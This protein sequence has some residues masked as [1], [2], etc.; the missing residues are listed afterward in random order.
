ML[1]SKFHEHTS[2]LHNY[3]GSKQFIQNHENANI[4]NIGQG[5]EAMHRKYKG[6]KR[7]GGQVC[8]RSSD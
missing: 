4:R 3:A 6:L 8:N 2:S 1:F 5:E 7:G